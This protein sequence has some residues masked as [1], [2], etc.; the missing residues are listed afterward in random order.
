M[1]IQRNASDSVSVANISHAAAVAKEPT[2]AGGSLL[3]ATV[4]VV[5]AV[6]SAARY[7]TRGQSGSATY[8]AAATSAS[9]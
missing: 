6:V 8:V 3:E 7:E 5:P 4:I 1:A 9:T 2:N